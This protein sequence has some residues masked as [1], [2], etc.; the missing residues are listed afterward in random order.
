MYTI[1]DFDGR[2]GRSLNLEGFTNFQ[3]P[4]EYTDLMKAVSEGKLIAISPEG[5]KRLNQDLM[6]SIQ[7]EFD[8]YDKLSSATIE[9]KKYRKLLVNCG[10]N[11]VQEYLVKAAEN[12]ESDSQIEK[13]DEYYALNG[14]IRTEKNEPI[15]LL[16]KGSEIKVA[17]GVML[18]RIKAENGV[19]VAKMA[20]C[21]AAIGVSPTDSPYDSFERSLGKKYSWEFCNKHD[22]VAELAPHPNGAP[23]PENLCRSYN[24]F[25]SSLSSNM[26]VLKLCKAY[27]NNMKDEQNYRLDSD[28]YSLLFSE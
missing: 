10:L 21:E 26:R 9:I 8:G 16:K 12:N 3:K 20:E 22:S 2:S 14:G 7:D 1:L 28:L 23:V 24:N 18:D 27:I 15:A 4:V 25:F 17:L 19:L 13:G 5:Q 6:K 11:D